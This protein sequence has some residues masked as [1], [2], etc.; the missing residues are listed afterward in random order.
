MV[1]EEIF[2]YSIAGDFRKSIFVE[3]EIGCEGP[4]S[5]YR[6]RVPAYFCRKSTVP[7]VVPKRSHDGRRGSTRY[8]GAGSSRPAI[9]KFGPIALWIYAHPLSF[10]MSIFCSLAKLV[11]PR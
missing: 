9:I 8:A 5:G 4:R 3:A 6:K 7:F 1:M 11:L 2:K 10:E